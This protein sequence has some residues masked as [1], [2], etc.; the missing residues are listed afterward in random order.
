MAANFAIDRGAQNQSTIQQQAVPG[1]MND[2]FDLPSET[3]PAIPQQDQQEST[4]PEEE[5]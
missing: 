4:P 2:D 3:Q 5:N 1:Q